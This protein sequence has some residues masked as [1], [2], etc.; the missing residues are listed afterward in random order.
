MIGD[1]IRRARKEAGFT[2]QTLADHLGDI[3]RQSVQKWE[4]GESFPDRGRW[5]E[6]EQALKVFPGWLFN[7]LVKYK[8]RDE[9][10]EISIAPAT[11]TFT[12]TDIGFISV[13]KASLKLSARGGD[14]V[15]DKGCKDVYQFS[16]EWLLRVCQPAHAVLFDIDGP[17]MEPVFNDKDTVLVDRGAV[18]LHSDRIYAI[19]L[20]DTVS[21]K[22][23]RLKVSGEVE[24]ISDNPDK[25]R[26]PNEVVERDGIRIL[27]QVVW[28]GGLV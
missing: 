6:I 11:I 8:D 4:S 21:V 18:D 17:S 13:R 26:F 20:S 24:I 28:R 22:R 12:P 1:E 19:E 2:Q 15:Y 9:D 27:G 10:P 25:T 23:L 7:L 14:F 16:S 3:T 5:S